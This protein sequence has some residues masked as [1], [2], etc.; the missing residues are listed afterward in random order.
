MKTLQ[1]TVPTL[2]LAAIAAV[3]ASSTVLAQDHMPIR[4][5]RPAQTLQLHS[6]DNGCPDGWVASSAPAGCQPGSLTT[7]ESGPSQP[8]EAGLPPGECPEG[9]SQATYPLNPQLGCMPDN[10]AAPSTPEYSPTS[11]QL[12][13]VR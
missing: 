8:F 4:T 2:A 13:R 11:A 3:S 10:I 1:L 7:V 9:F 6:I 5:R 12:R